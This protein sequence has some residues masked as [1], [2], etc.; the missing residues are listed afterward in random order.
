[1]VNI[2]KIR[3]FHINFMR[4]HEVPQLDLFD[5]YVIDGF[6]FIGLAIDSARLRVELEMGGAYTS[7]GLNE[8][9]LIDN[10]LDKSVSVIKEYIGLDYSVDDILDDILDEDLDKDRCFYLESVLYFK[11]NQFGKSIK[12]HTL[13]VMNYDDFYNRYSEDIV[14]SHI[15]SNNEDFSES[16]IKIKTYLT[17]EEV[18][19]KFA[20]YLIN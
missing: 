11:T 14:S 20:G 6:D 10:D 5:K 13:M 18:K 8:L 2:N 16:C 1:M 3:I 9:Y 12:Q 17:K 19:N 15:I 4:T 7:Y